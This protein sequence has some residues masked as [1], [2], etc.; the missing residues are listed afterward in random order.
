M[1][2]FGATLEYLGFR[3]HYFCTILLMRLLATKPRRSITS[4]WALESKQVWGLFL[5]CFGYLTTQGIR[6]AVLKLHGM[7][8]THTHTQ[9]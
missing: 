9:G 7:Q 1:S 4:V 8:S 6:T 3:S 2:H 5:I